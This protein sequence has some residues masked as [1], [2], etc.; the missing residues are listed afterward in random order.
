VLI[1]AADSSSGQEN[2]GERTAD[3]PNILRVMTRGKKFREIQEGVGALLEAARPILI[4]KQDVREEE[5][6]GGL[7]GVIENPA[8]GTTRQLRK[9]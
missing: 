7:G 9:T 6:K 3:C 5:Q 2:R 1:A 4:S 8:T